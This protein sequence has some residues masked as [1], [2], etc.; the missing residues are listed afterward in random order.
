MAR[1][2]DEPCDG[3]AIGGSRKMAPWLERGSRGFDAGEAVYE[4]VALA[5]DVKAGVFGDLQCA[6]LAYAGGK[7]VYSYLSARRPSKALI[8]I[9]KSGCRGPIF[10]SFRV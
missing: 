9:V 4:A 7:A 6:P 2:A 10:A 5:V 3:A 8:P 1:N